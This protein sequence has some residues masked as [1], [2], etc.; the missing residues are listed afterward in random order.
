MPAKKGF[1][2]FLNELRTE[3]SSPVSEKVIVSAK[4]TTVYGFK[5]SAYL[6]KIN[7]TIT[8]NT[9]TVFRFRRIMR[10]NFIG[11]QLKTQR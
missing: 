5:N 3:K 9:R 8:A 4:A 10:T 1:T 11:W 6:P 2:I 7:P